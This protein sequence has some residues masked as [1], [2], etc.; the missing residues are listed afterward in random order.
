MFFNASETATFIS[1]CY[2]FLHSL[3]IKMKFY[4]HE[5]NDLVHELID[6]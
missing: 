6:A 2:I 4:L 5:I 3:S 1:F